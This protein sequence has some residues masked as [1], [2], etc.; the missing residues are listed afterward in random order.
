MGKKIYGLLAI[1]LV[2]ALVIPVGSA[3]A[4]YDCKL[5]AIGLIRIDRA[6]SVIKGFVF[7]GDNDGNDLRFE[8]IN[9]EFNDARTPLIAQTQMPLLVHH[10]EYNP[11]K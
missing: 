6:N 1:G 9:I 3:Y 8:F 4:T 10:I 2:C 5:S 7:F 11:A